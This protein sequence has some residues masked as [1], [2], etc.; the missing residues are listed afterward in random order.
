MGLWEWITGSGTPAHEQ[1][2]AP[3]K[4]AEKVQKPAPYD[5]VNNVTGGGQSPSL[6]IVIKDRTAP[7]VPIVVGGSNP[8]TPQARQPLDTQN[9]GVGNKYQVLKDTSAA[10]RTQEEARQRG[11]FFVPSREDF[12][13]PNI[14]PERGNSVDLPKSR[15]MKPV[16]IVIQKEKP[17]PPKNSLQFPRP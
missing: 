15:D 17:A 12:K 7:A 10:P 2:T 8:Q 6:P 3:P 9:A 16:D 1:K 14:N 5:P 13:S 11:I 4:P